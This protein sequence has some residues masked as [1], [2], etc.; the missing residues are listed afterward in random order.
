M[1]VNEIKNENNLIS[2]SITLTKSEFDNYFIRCESCGEIVLKESAVYTEGGYYCPDCVSCCDVCGECYPSD[3]LYHTED[4]SYS[5][6]EHCYDTETYVCADCG[7]HFRYSESLTEIEDESYCEACADNHRD[8]IEGYHTF[9]EYG[10]IEFCGNE[11]RSHTPYMGFELEVDSTSAVKR[12]WIVNELKNKFG[13]FFHYEE[14]GSLRYGWENISQPAS[15]SYHMENM[16]AYKEM[17]SIL[18]DNGLRS[19][20]TNTCGFHIHIDREY[21][22][23]KQDSA[24]AKLLYIF[25][26]YRSELMI[27]SRRTEQES[28]SWARSRKS[29]TNNKSWIKKAVKD[30]KGYQDHSLRYYA[31]NLT[32]SETVEIRLWKGTLNPKTFESTLRFTARL[33][34]I[35]KN[36]TAVELSKMTFDDLLGNNPVIRSYWERALSRTK[37]I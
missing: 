7:R 3:S 29:E 33:A 4:S 22:E 32:N 8:L 1:N 34:E 13:D 12:N 6:C 35:C 36:I 31:V 37:E 16:T 17:F 18:S 14:D 24:I 28:D 27:F 11:S 20:D 15:L 23:N 10:D 9:K 25:E 19:H 5:Y 30:S 2:L 26:K 21:F